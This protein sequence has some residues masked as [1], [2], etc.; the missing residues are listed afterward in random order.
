MKCALSAI[1]I[2]VGLAP[3]ALSQDD[4]SERV[5]TETKYKNTLAVFREPQIVPR[6]TNDSV[7][8]RLLVTAT[9]YH[10]VLIRIEKAGARQ[11]L[12]AKW[13]SGQVGYD[14]GNFK[15][16]KTVNLTQ[17]QWRT[18]NRLLEQASFWTLPYEQAE[19]QPNEKGE[20]TVCL[21]GVD[22]F[23]EGSALGKYHVVDRYCPDEGAF[24]TAGMYMVKLARL[25][26]GLRLK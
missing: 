5:R 22:W 12:R 11:V 21:D 19:P 15:G 25:N 1:L 18:L 13:L 14:W 23:L 10:P 7:A 8:Y 26:I 4:A 24:K 20:A 3:L 9:F 6:T 16:E 17:E 2:I